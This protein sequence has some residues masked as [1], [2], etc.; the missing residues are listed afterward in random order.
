[1]EST[2]GIEW[3]NEFECVEWSTL[4]K[5]GQSASES[6]LKVITLLLVIYKIIFK[7]LKSDCME[8]ME[9][10]ECVS[11]YVCVFASF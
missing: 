10:S 6:Q 9:W 11:E 8:C 2:S 5:S 7:S 4:W 1:M 3:E